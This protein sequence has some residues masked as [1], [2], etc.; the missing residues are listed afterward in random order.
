MVRNLKIST[1]HS[2]RA[3]Y[4]EQTEISWPDLV[5]K[6]GRVARTTETVA[7]WNHLPKSER[8][9]IKD[10][11]GFVGGTLQDG[12]RKAAN[13]TERHLVTLD[14]DSIPTEADPWIVIPMILD[15]AA[16][17]YSTHS[18]SSKT[19]RYRIVIPL[20]RPVSPE[21]YEAVS[22]MLA[23]S[24]GIDYCDDTT[25]EPHRLM[26]WPSASKD[27]E[28]RFEVHQGPWLSVDHYLKKYVDWRDTTTWP[29]S[30]RQNTI[31][32]KSLQ[33]Q[34]DPHAKAGIVGAFC[35]TYSIA[36]V[37][38]EFLPHCYSP[39]DGSRYTYAQGST[40]GGLVIY[41]EK[42][43]F[44]HHS[45]DPISGKLCNAFDLVR[46]HLFGELDENI[47]HNTKSTN[48]PSFK[49]MAEKAEGLPLVAE[50]LKKEHLSEIIGMFQ[51]TCVENT[52]TQEEKDQESQW[53]YDLEVHP[54]TGATLATIDNVILI[55]TH[56]PRM[57]ESYYWDEFKER[58]M[59]EGDFPWCKFKDR[60]T[61]EWTDNDDAGLRWELEKMFKIDQ[62]A[63]IRDGIDLAI[64]LRK[65]H[66]VREYLLGLKWDGIP[67]G[68]TL[69][70]THLGAED[71]DYTRQVTRKALLG[72]VAR[73]MQPGCKHDQVLV[74]VGPQGC[75]KSTT[76][77]MMGKKWFSD[78]LYTM[79]GKEAYEQLE[80]HWIIE[81]AEMAATRKAE[82]E[83]FKHFTSK[84]ED[85]YRAAYARRTQTHLR[86]CAF[87]GT[88]N[89]IE[90]LRDYTGSRRVWPVTVAK[91][92]QGKRPVLTQDI[93]DQI[94]AEIVV[95]YEN[96]ERWYLP[97]ELE[98]VAF[99]VQQAHTETNDK[100]GLVEKFLEKRLPKDWI[101]KDLTERR[102]FWDG[103]VG[104]LVEGTE[105]RQK[106]CAV[107]IWC[108]LFEGNSRQYTQANTREIN[109]ILKQIEGW[110]PNLRV[111][112][113]AHY[114]RQRGYSRKSVNSKNV[115]DVTVQE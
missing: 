89:D 56:D 58:A 77:S 62:I 104:E 9:E 19:P 12:I 52:K 37:I 108:E 43:A 23:K 96:G 79:T 25:Y 67:R 75:R 91:Y 48:M 20:D 72:A 61:N 60:P 42:F 13:I 27:A 102:A 7:E 73:I 32:G 51:E 65:R 59:V 92:E 30:S 29:R 4:W 84:Q 8:D 90:F 109:N 83:Q 50:A 41:D 107:E 26:Y 98:E 113:G 71:S 63:K 17:V 39:C 74:L 97:P 93:V 68:D 86:Q 10:V 5:E 78:S 80:G 103:T 31:A 2:R 87:F 21:E 112:C 105:V 100:Q 99:Q 64:A 69:F 95:A 106:V 1:G 28:V 55:L 110:E 115:T 35:R 45:T 114:G 6:L 70:I 24:I 33:Q 101:K 3:T 34:E 16:V 81:I 76:L 18:H 22:R 54:K 88:T 11:G 85:T 14:L 57:K 66:P 38:S 36:D 40:F 53:I 111:D 44:S 94:W 49:K 82:T 46:I 47:A 15:I